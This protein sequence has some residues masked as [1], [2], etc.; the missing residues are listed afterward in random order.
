[1]REQERGVRDQTKVSG[2]VPGE[3]LGTEVPTSNS[4]GGR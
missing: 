2:L 1:M 3:V 4:L